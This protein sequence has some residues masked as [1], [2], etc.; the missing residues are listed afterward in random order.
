MRVRLPLRLAVG[1]LLLDGTP[2]TASEVRA[3]LEPSY[4]GERQIN[5]ENIEGQLQA[6]KGVGIV[7]IC[8][9]S[10]QGIAY[11]ITPDGRQRVLRNL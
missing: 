10:D 7:T 9:E 11:G 2:R 5:T 8:S 4:A 6:L 1:R 3:A